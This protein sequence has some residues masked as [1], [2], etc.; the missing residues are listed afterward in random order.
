MKFVSIFIHFVFGCAH[1]NQN[2]SILDTYVIG[3]MW[4]NFRCWVERYNEK[5]KEWH[6]VQ[7]SNFSFVNLAKD[8]SD[9]STVEANWKRKQKNR[10]ISG[11]WHL[12]FF[13]AQWYRSE[14][15]WNE[16][17]QRRESKYKNW[18]KKIISRSIHILASDVQW[19]CYVPGNFPNWFFSPL[20]FFCFM[21]YKRNMCK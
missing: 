11:V 20:F 6:F 1:P 13:S 21:H 8:E 2:K 15:T 7:K 19:K 14:S 10:R 12:L 18:D 5:N 4:R 17:V 9:F 3:F 16:N